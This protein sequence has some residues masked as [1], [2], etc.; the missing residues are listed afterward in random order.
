VTDLA[1]LA[2][3][4]LALGAVY[5]LVAVGFVVVYK[6]SGVINFAH[7]SL[8]L[9]GAYLAFNASV[10]WGLP[11]VAGVAVAV[12]AAALLALAVERVVLR[13]MVGQPPH[14]VIL[15]TIGLS[16][17]LDQVV[18][19]VWGFGQQPLD[20]PW[21]AG[22]VRVGGAV[23]ATVDL[24]TVVLAAASLAALGA[25]F[26]R[27]RLGL[28]MRAAAADTE[29]ALAQGIAPS[30]VAGLAWVLAAATATLAGVL[31]SSGV[32]AAH[33]G[34]GH[35]ALRAFPAVILGG[36]ESVPGA[37]AG[38]VAIGLLEVLTAGYAPA[39]A[40]WLGANAHQ[41]V[42]YLV[43]VAVLLVRPAGLFGGRAVRR[44]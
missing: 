34:L 25:F 16:I 30:M 39:H 31:L 37:A 8:M 4:G 22:T 41:I 43:M 13:R 32:A 38:G 26:R 12:A 40:P 10:T 1:Q 24:A 11:F 27:A 33:P 15:A 20:D 5:A 35:Q 9:L 28:A 17:V 14:A 44:L 7:G 36:L 19:A 6:A 3:K 23:L 29:A 21:G 42:P 2:V 18:T